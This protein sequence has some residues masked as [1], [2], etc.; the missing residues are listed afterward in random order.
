MMDGDGGNTCND[1]LPKDFCRFPIVVPPHVK[2]VH[3]EFGGEV[4]LLHAEA[5]GILAVGHEI[6]LHEGV[7]LA[8][9]DCHGQA[10]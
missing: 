3:R 1:L 7:G 4:G 8:I 2:L 5:D 10:N 9:L 6:R